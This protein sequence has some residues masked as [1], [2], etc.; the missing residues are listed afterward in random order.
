MNCCRCCSW[1][2]YENCMHASKYPCGLCIW[3]F[4]EEAF[5]ASRSFIDATPSKPIVNQVSKGSVQ[6]VA[7]STSAVP[8]FRSLV[9]TPTFSVSPSSFSLSRYRSEHHHHHR[10]GILGKNHRLSQSNVHKINVLSSLRS[11]T[12]DPLKDPRSREWPC[13]TTA[14]VLPRTSSLKRRYSP[15][16]S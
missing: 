7:M 12:E 3:S 4:I 1:P 14:I 8:P 11:I 10:S 9:Q 13:S 15:S 5:D 2:P 6:R 16:L